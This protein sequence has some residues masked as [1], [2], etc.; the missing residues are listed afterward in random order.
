MIALK[1]K[2]HS[3]YLPLK[4]TRLS[5]IISPYLAKFIKHN[6]SIIAFE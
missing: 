1:E 4:L 3:V 2:F 5:I 6:R